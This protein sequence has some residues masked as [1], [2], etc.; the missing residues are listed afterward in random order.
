MAYE[1]DDDDTVEEVGEAR[2]ARASIVEAAWAAALTTEIRRALGLSGQKVAVLIVPDST[3]VKAIA[4]RIDG[5]DFLGAGWSPIQREA[6]PKN[7]DAD[8]GAGDLVR[9][10]EKGRNVV[11]IAPAA[12]MLPNALV[13]AA[14]LTIVIARPNADVVGDAI[15]RFLG[16]KTKSMAIG[17]GALDLHA[18]AAAFRPGSVQAIVDRIARAAGDARGEKPSYDVPRLEEAIEFGEARTWGLAVAADVTKFLNSG[19]RFDWSE[20]EASVILHSIPG[21]GK[22]T[23]ASS[24]A[25]HIDGATLIKT[26]ISELFASSPG[27]LDSVIKALR[28]VYRSAEAS[29]PA[30]ILWDEVDALPSRAGLDSRSASWWTS[31]ITDFMLMT[32]LPRPGVIQIAATNY[33]EKVDPALRRPGRFGRAIEMHPPNA[34]GIVSMARFQLRGDL[35]NADL[36]DIGQLAAGSTAADV[37]AIVRRARG[38]ARAADRP[39]RAD[40]L[41]EAVV[42]PVTVAPADLERI[43]CHEAGHAV[44]GLALSIDVLTSLRIGGADGALGSTLHRRRN[45]L[46][47]RETIEARV[48]MMLGGRAAEL[49]CFGSISSGSNGDLVGATAQIAAVHASLG[50]GDTL[51]AFD[52]PDLRRG[53]LPSPLRA[54]VEAELRRLQDLAVTTVRTHRRAIEAIAEALARRRHLTGDA[55]RRIFADNPPHAPRARRSHKETPEC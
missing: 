41:T 21:L 20:I 55:A 39:L 24:L 12:A 26:S 40:D 33:L 34:D 2:T 43:T 27:Y 3:W 7:R 5:E 16:R 50:L 48:T 9:Y 37:M 4:G 14:D 15:R 8:A 44:V 51:S 30:V 22:T 6:H 10:L 54:V 31:V 49:V 53:W 36:S 25:R 42:G 28:E 11:G 52:D 45:E 29:I 46:E 23:F 13:A 17:S 1:H 18:L 19:G 35:A 32:A 38:I 47:T